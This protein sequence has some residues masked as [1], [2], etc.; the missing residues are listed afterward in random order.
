MLA[1]VTVN[2]P[3]IAAA[4]LVNPGPCGT[5]G[6]VDINWFDPVKIP[7]LLKSV[8]GI[9]PSTLPIFLIY[10]AVL[11]DF[12][13]GDCCI[14]GYHSAATTLKGAQTY[15][16]AG[17]LDSGVFTNV[18]DVLPLGHEV[19][20]WMDDPFV[21]NATPPWGHSGQ[22]S[23]CQ[24]N[25]EV[26]DALSGITFF[27]ESLNGFTY[28]VQDLTFVPW[29]AEAASSFS[30][31]GWFSFFGTFRSASTPCSAVAATD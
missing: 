12:S 2:V 3:K 4:K 29:F 6:A 11:A 26:G 8:P 31:N 25:L 28:H 14:L 27:D 23:G 9:K 1:P 16:V 10:D 15:A 21:N 5:I 7:K 18:G 30:V 13:T 17:F 20:E 22:V 19:A 24:S